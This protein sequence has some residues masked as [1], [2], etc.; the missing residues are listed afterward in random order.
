LPVNVEGLTLTGSLAVDGTGNA[1]PNLITGNA[2]ANVLSGA[3]GDDTLTGNAGD[4]RLDGGAG[5]DWLAGGRGADRYHFG[6]GYGWDT[7]LDNDKTAGVV[8]TVLF[9]E[10]ITQLGT[11]FARNGNDLD[12]GFSGST[13]R[14]T[15][16]DWYLGARYQIEQFV[17]ADGS[18]LSAAQVATLVSAMATF[19]ASADGSTSSSSVAMFW[20]EPVLTVP[21][22]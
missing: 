2:A 16:K 14:L 12:I 6:R 13:D 4:D 10:G 9:G 5:N 17:Y 8:D 18:T 22:L 21:V 19:E 1:L 7:I 3:G 20:R 11:S 15:A